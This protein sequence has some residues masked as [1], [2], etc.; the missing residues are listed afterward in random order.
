MK[1]FADRLQDSILKN[2]SVIVAGFDP[3]IDGFPAFLLEQAVTAKTKPAEALK[4]LLVEFHRAALDEIRP[5]VAAVKINTAFFEQYGLCGLEAMQ[6]IAAEVKACGLL[7]IADAKRGDIGSTAQ[8]YS[9]A[10]LGHTSAFNEHFSLLDADALTI[11]P[12]LGFDTLDSFLEDSIEHK[13]GIFVLVRTSNPGSGSLQSLRNNSGK[14]ASEIIAAWIA[15]HSHS[16]K[17][18]CGLSGLGAVVGATY[19]KEAEMLR[20]I[21]KDSFFL[22][23]GFGTQGASAQDLD[24]V[25]LRDKKSGN[26]GGAVINI[27]RALFSKF[28]ESI[29]N[30]KALKTEIRRRL[31]LFNSEINSNLR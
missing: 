26:A 2:S 1:L 5:S 24:K 4:N 18:E 8:A 9:R 31:S 25:F 22:L 12:F 13:K 15:E 20:D 11:N 10:F 6:I 23:P 7:L 19:P 14:T 27:S 21:M 30:T 16:L 28:P 29:K 17:G 3:V